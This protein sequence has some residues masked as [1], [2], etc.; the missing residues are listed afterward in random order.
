MK[1]GK[2]SRFGKGGLSDKR[3]ARSRSPVP[4]GPDCDR[5][6]RGASVEEVDDDCDLVMGDTGNPR[7]VRLASA[8]APLSS[9]AGLPS[10]PPFSCR[11]PAAPKSTQPRA[12]RAAQRAVL[13]WGVLLGFLV[14]ANGRA[15][16]VNSF[17]P[18][19]S[20]PLMPRSPFSPPHTCI[21]KYGGGD[22]TLC[23]CLLQPCHCQSPHNQLCYSPCLS[24]QCYSP[25][26]SCYSCAAGVA[27]CF[28]CLH[29]QPAA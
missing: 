11:S 25:C 14:L 17:P 24:S 16:R 5:R 28:S 13:G 15:N 23:P 3:R 10:H 12:R 6:R 22:L 18:F 19:D 9:S 21:M 1:G 7:L 26:C 8:P 20:H 27:C 2:T 29:C 4:R